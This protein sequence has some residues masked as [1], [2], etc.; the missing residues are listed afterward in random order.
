VVMVG[1]VDRFG[2]H[3]RLLRGRRDAMC[4][5]GHSGSLVPA[6]RSFGDT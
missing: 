2:V 5:L 3:G 6:A 4:R 1:A